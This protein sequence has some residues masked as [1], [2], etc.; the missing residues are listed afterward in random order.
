MQLFWTRSNKIILPM[1]KIIRGKQLIILCHK[2]Q[3]HNHWPVNKANNTLKRLICRKS[4]KFIKEPERAGKSPWLKKRGIEMEAFPQVVRGCRKEQLSSR[5][6]K[7]YQSHI[8]NMRVS[9]LQ[10]LLE[11]DLAKLWQNRLVGHQRH[12][13][14]T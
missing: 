5:L 8:V 6:S 14:T 9:G 11:E 3:I 4:S 13:F 1:P 10:Y 12:R 7:N 2:M